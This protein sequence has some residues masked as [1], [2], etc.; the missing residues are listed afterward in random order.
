MW[1][2]PYH[3]KSGFTSEFSGSQICN[4]KERAAGFEEELEKAVSDVRLETEGRVHWEEGAKAAL[5]SEQV[6]REKG[7]LEYRI[8]SLAKE[9]ESLR[10]REKRIIRKWGYLPC[11]LPHQLSHAW[12]PLPSM[13]WYHQSPAG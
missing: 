7:I 8:E 12:T 4:W 9:K 3:E 13:L 2:Q 6:K 10:I 11:P 5:L 1:R